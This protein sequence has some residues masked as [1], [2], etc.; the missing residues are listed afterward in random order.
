MRVMVGVSLIGLLAACEPLNDLGPADG[1]V[2]AP[3]SISY[4]VE[5]SGDPDSP[6][7]LTIEW[8][9]DGDPDLAVWHVYSRA[10]SAVEFGLRGTTTSPSFHDV[11]I[12]H[13]EYYV[14]AEDIDGGES[15]PSPIV[16]V[17][18]RLA[19]GAPGSLS[20]TSL[21]GAIALVWGDQ[22]ALNEPA[23]F[24][25]Y[26]VYSAAYDLDNDIC[27][28]Q[29]LLE[30]TTVAPEFIAGALANG[31]PRCFGVSAISVEGWESLWSPV[32]HDTPRPEARN[33]ALMASDIDVTRSGFRFW[34]DGNG[35]FFVQDQELGLVGDGSVPTMDLRLDRVAGQL[36]LAPV[37]A[38]TGIEFYGAGPVADLNSIDFAPNQSYS[39]SPIAAQTGFGYVVEMDGGDGFARF[40]S[41]RVTHVGQDLIIFDWGFQTDPGNPE[42]LRAG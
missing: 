17:D 37:R 4:R 25:H 31:Q 2:R 40:G 36:M 13:L 32:V 24:S 38:G 39:A 11:G 22:P 5:P 26:R 23:G 33:V 12:P 16:V 1:S 15:A 20:P 34:L 28:G 9:D 18:E 10:S 27:Q 8:N 29:W 7:G 30:G 3:S 41:L 35:D 19:L 6:L 21:D 14:T 42:L